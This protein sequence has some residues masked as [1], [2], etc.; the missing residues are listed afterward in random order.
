MQSLYKHVCFLLLSPKRF[1]NKLVPTGLPV[2]ISFFL[3]PLLVVRILSSLSQFQLRSRLLFSI[4]NKPTVLERRL[5]AATATA[6]ANVTLVGDHYVGICCTGDERTLRRRIV[7]I[8]YA[9]I[10]PITQS[11]Y[12]H[13]RQMDAILGVLELSK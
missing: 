2:D 1:S 9:Y 7:K 11:W 10:Y 8:I 13:Q 6:T 12:F 3:F 4:T 5:V